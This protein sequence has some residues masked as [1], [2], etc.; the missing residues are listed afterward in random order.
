MPVISPSRG[1]GPYWLPMY[2]APAKPLTRNR[3]A[4]FDR[5]RSPYRMA[6]PMPMAAMT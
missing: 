6:M 1:P 3:M 2:R 5:L 4:T